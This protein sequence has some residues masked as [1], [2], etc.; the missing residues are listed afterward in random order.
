MAAA[1][2]GV[3][4]LEPPENAN[5]VEQM[6]AWQLTHIPPSLHLLPTY[7]TLLPSPHL[8]RRQRHH[9]RGRRRRLIPLLPLPAAA[10]HHPHQVPAPPRRLYELYQRLAVGASAVDARRQPQDRVGCV[11]RED[12]APPRGRRVEEVAV[13]AV[14][15]AEEEEE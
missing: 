8:H 11:G 10:P 6:F 14:E 9:R 3:P 4:L 12:L 13:V 7:R 1:G 2:A 5:P 15:L